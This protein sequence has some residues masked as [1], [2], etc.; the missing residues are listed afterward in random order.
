MTNPYAMNG[1]S[2]AYPQTYRQPVSN[3]PSVLSMAAF[4]A[5]G[6]GAAGYLKNRFPV[7]KDG[8]V[9]DTFAKEVFENNLKKNSSADANKYFSELQNVLKKIDKISTPEGFKKLI[10]DNKNLIEDQCRG[11]SAESFAD[12]VNSTNLKDSKKA[13]KETLQ[14]IMNFERAKTKNAIKLAWNSEAKK[15]VQTPE[16]R[17]NKLFEVIKGT[18]NSMQ[19]KKALKYGGISAGV[20]GALTIAYKMLTSKKSV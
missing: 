6:G 17:D 2:Q 19:W 12:A 9:S 18:K 1:Y 13:L 15:F 8:A 11:I 4:G 3:G 20:M 14:A 7:G 10:T 5:V 16:F